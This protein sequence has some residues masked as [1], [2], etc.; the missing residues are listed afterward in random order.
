MSCACD[1]TR[2]WERA[3]VCAAM[4]DHCL[5]AR[6]DADGWAVAC[7]VSGRPLTDHAYAGLPCPRGHH[8]DARG[9]LRWMG[10]TWW[11]IPFP[12][13]WWRWATRWNELEPR[14]VLERMPGCGCIVALKARWQALVGR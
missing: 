14:D 6:K 4:C 8:P 9:R 1:D 2:V 7:T 12:L 13:R 3:A 5:A 11:G 10:V